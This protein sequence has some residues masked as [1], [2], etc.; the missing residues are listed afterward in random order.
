MVCT[1]R[2]CV[3][4]ILKSNVSGGYQFIPAIAP[5]SAGVVAM[6]G[7]EIVHATLQT[8]LPWLAGLNAARRYLEDRKLTCRNLCAVELRCPKPYPLQGFVEFNDLYRK[9]LL[10]W[11]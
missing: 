6:P 3:A 11:T 1:E 2:D 4:S 9:L 5:Y 7:F 10:D 8:P